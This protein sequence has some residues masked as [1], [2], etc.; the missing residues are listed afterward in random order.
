MVKVAYII[1]KE[2][3]FIDFSELAFF[4]CNPISRPT[5]SV[6]QWD[7]FPML[8]MSRIL[9]SWI[10]V[11]EIMNWDIYYFLPHDW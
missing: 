5:P 4:A 3:K 10:L 11:F 8:K 2:V 1:L 7:E 6:T 9:V